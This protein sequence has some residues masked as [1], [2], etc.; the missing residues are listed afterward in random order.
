M[1][2]TENHTEKS[3]DYFW[4]NIDATHYKNSGTH[5]LGLPRHYKNSGTHKLG[6]PRHY[7]NSGT[8]ELGLPRLYKN[9]GTHNSGTIFLEPE[10]CVPLFLEPESCVPAFWSRKIVVRKF[11]PILLLVTLF[12]ASFCSGGRSWI[13]KTIGSGTTIFLDYLH[14]WKAIFGHF[15]IFWNSP[16]S[17][18]FSSWR[19]TFLS[20]IFFNLSRHFLE[21]RYPKHGFCAAKIRRVSRRPPPVGREPDKENPGPQPLPG[22]KLK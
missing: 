18:R 16:V 4:R 17:K 13:E 21:K 1:N 6:L 15:Y 2:V 5:G 10:S 11:R 8:H 9:S 3:R 14:F 20:T 7:K 22:K 12:T 19:A